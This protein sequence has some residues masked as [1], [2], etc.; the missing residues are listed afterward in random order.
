MTTKKIQ[1]DANAALCGPGPYPVA[2]VDDAYDWS[3]GSKGPRIG[4][5]YTILRTADMEKVRVLV[6]DAAPLVNA[7][8]VA[9]Y[10]AAMQFLR[11]AFEGFTASVSADKAG[12]LR[13]YA[14]AEAIHIVQPQAGGKKEV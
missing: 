12:N 4:T 8:T 11:V 2:G 13:I 1:L 3:S 9:Q 5:Y 6:R 7:E 10:T 14:E